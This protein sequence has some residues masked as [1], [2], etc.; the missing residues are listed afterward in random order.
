MEQKSG[1]QI[2]QKAFIQSVL[3]LLAL[4]IVSGILTLVIPAGEYQRI[5]VDG[6]E[7]IVPDSF[8]FTARPDYP[9]WRWFIA[10]L[11]VLTG[12]DSLLIIVLTVF[13]LMVGV[14][15]AVMDRSGIL[16]SALGRI[17]KR[18]ENQKYTLLLMITFFFMTLGA[19][20]GI[21]EEVV[22]LVPLMIALAYALGWDTLTGLGMSILATNMGFSAAITNP[23]TI[24][25]AQGL[26]RPHF[27]DRATASSFSFSFIF[28]W[29]SFS[30]AMRKKWKRTPKPRLFLKKN[31]PPARN[32]ATSPLPPSRTK[33]RA[34]RLR[35]SF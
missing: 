21:F 6:R 20:F 24:G 17:V 1:A 35:L 7:T 31:N 13:L 12:P 3:I 8:T 16:K 15:F 19:F 23:F 9:I 30:S 32:T 34:P 26:A 27:R 2:S 33:I 5:E 28:C 18:F 4:M 14:A 22:P 10:P 11:E 25:I 29:R